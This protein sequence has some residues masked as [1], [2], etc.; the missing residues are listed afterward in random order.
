MVAVF[1]RLGVVAFGGPAAHTA[2]MREE[3]VRRRGWV[4]DQRF[5][6]LVGATQL[7]P[8]PNSTELA[9]HLGHDRAGWRGLV[10][11][12]VCFIV[13][14]A[15]IVGVIAWAYVEHGD[16]PVVDDV[17]AGRDADVS[18]AHQLAVAVHPHL[19][20]GVLRGGRHDAQIDGFTLAGAPARRDRDDSNVF[21]LALV[22]RNH[23]D[24]DARGCCQRGLAQSVAAG[25]N[26]VA[27][28]YD[29]GGR[30][31]R[32]LGQATPDG[33]AQIGAVARELG[34]LRRWRVAAFAQWIFDHGVGR[35]SQRADAIAIAHAL[36]RDL[37]FLG[38]P[39]LRA[40]Y[41]IDAAT[42][43]DGHDD[44]QAIDLFA[45]LHTQHREGGCDRG[46]SGQE[47]HRQGAAAR[48]AKA[49]ARQ[50]RGQP[51]QQHRQWNGQHR[52]S[53]P[54]VRH[55]HAQPL[56]REHQSRRQRH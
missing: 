50:A 44:A 11:A 43:I 4:D 24:A 1:L 20:F 38:N 19:D 51:Q 29:T 13:P 32:Y 56:E 42:A 30:V 31:G 21:E 15:L 33:R 40:G 36:L 28:Q 37:H 55:R 47:R 22:E 46:R 27:E 5:V 48:A 8:G 3:L 25:R 39:R 10:A 7:V 49:E 17:F 6:D 16:T 52:A 2:M 26:A 34:A 35:E 14:A 9:I 23:V 54:H 41:Q 53:Q 12:G 18:A 45:Q